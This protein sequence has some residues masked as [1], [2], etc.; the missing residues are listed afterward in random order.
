MFNRRGQLSLLGGW[1]EA[2]QVGFYGIGTNTS[3]DDRTNYLFNQPYASALLTVFP[4]RRFMMLRGGA[5]WSRWS[6]EPG[7]GSSFPSVE[8]R[9][10]PETLPGLGAEVT[11]LHT[12]A[13][14]GL[15][16]RTSPGYSRRGAFIGATLHNYDD[17]DK[18]FSFH[19]AE[20]EA[21]AH[22]PILRETWVLS[23]RGRM[24]HSSEKDG[25]QTPFFMLPSLGGGSTL[26][27]YSSWRFRD[28]NSLLLQAEWRVMVN[29]YLDLAFFY[30]AG[31]V[32]AST[33]DL[34]LDGL[35]DD[36][37]IGFRFHGP[38]ST[39]LRV[40]FARSNETSFRFIFS[41]SASF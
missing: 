14:I 37:G 23:L 33:K 29:R 39:P 31:K 16:G 13:T 11:Y 18:A 27:G 17:R 35:K 15:D 21:I 41:S 19:I 7:E 28:Q 32:T 9:Y 1:R 38:F 8:T 24:Q 12:Q 36:F 2:T 3:K 22:L 40:E 5:E 4:T 25:Q 26:R 6:Q 20:Y 30:D 10:T 34:D